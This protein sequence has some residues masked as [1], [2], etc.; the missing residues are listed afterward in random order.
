MQVND[1]LVSKWGFD[2]T[3]VDF[4]LVVGATGSFVTVMELDSIVIETK[5]DYTG[6]AVPSESIINGTKMR[7]KVN[8]LGHIKMTDYAYAEKWDGM[9]QSFSTYA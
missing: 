3:N 8:G 2:Q 6:L 1:I 4:Y 7:R 9:P 5:A